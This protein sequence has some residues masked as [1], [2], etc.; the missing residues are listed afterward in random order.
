[1]NSSKSS[2]TSYLGAA[3]N[4]RRRHQNSIINPIMMLR[5][6]L[7][8]AIYGIAFLSL[9]AQANQDNYLNKR[10]MM[11]SLQANREDD[12]RLRQLEEDILQRRRRTNNDYHSVDRGGYIQT[13]TLSS[14]VPHTHTATISTSPT[15]A[16]RYLQTPSE[17]STPL[18]TTPKKDK[19]TFAVV[20]KQLIEFFRPTS[21]GCFDHASRLSKANNI[22][23][24]CLYVGPSEAAD[25]G[26]KQAQMVE[27]ILW[28]EPSE[29][30]PIDG[31]AV[32]VVDEDLMT[33]ILDRARLELGIPV[34]TFDSD[35]PESERS[36]YIGTNNSFFGRQLGRQMES[37]RPQGGTYAIISGE[38]TNLQARANGIIQE[39]IDQTANT[40]TTWEQLEGSPFDAL[41][42]QTLALEKMGEWAQQNP[43]VLLSVTGLPMRMKTLEN[44]DTESPWADFVD[45]HRDRG[46]TLLCADASPHQL[47]FLNYDYVNGLAGQLPYDMGIKSMDTL[48]TLYH[49]P[50]AK[51]ADSEGGDFIG[52]NVVWHVHIPLKLPP[53]TVDMN[54]VGSLKY[55]GYTLFGVIAAFALCLMAWVFWRRNV[56]VIKVAQPNFLLMIA[57]GVIIMASCM[58]PLGMDDF[59]VGGVCM[60]EDPSVH[61][62]AICMGIPWT[63]SIG[64]VLTFS[65]MYA[66]TRRINAIFHSEGGFARVKVSERDVLP[67][68]LLLMTINV[69]ILICWTILDPL[70]YQ[71]QA[72]HSRDEWNRVISTYG[73]CKSENSAA[74]LG[75]IMVVNFAVLVLANWQSYEARNLDAEFSESKYIT[76]CMA[77][78][79]QA[80]I[81]GVP[82]LF[83]VHNLPQAYYLVFVLLCF[84]ICMVILMIMFVPKILY[85]QEFLQLSPAQQQ[86]YMQSAIRRTA[87]NNR[88]RAPSRSSLRNSRGTSS[89]SMALRSMRSL[90]P[91]SR[92]GSSG[93][94]K[95]SITKPGSSSWMQPE[96]QM[97][98]AR[99]RVESRGE[100]VT[101]NRSLGEFRPVGKRLSWSDRSLS[102]EIVTKTDR[103]PSLVSVKELPRE[104]ET[105]GPLSTSTDDD[106]HE[107]GGYQMDPF[108][109]M[110][111]D[112]GGSLCL[113]TNTELSFSEHSRLHDYSQHS[114]QK[115]ATVVG[116]NSSVDIES[117][118]SDSDDDNGEVRIRFTAPHVSEASDDDVEEVRFSRDAGPQS[119]GS[120]D[121]EEEVRIPRNATPLINMQL[122]K[123]GEI[124]E[125]GIQKHSAHDME[126]GDDKQDEEE[127]EI[128]CEKEEEA[129]TPPSQMNEKGD[130]FVPSPSPVT[131]D[132]SGE[133]QAKGS[134]SK[135]TVEEDADASA[136]VICTA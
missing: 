79:L 21:L 131:V 27:D 124:A 57:L 135:E 85:T 66:K 43:T 51:L 61:C 49:N 5:W 122:A 78:M 16:S 54:R 41:N 42:N 37:L 40:D 38:S 126:Q 60:P 30:T 106:P 72:D 47:T 82:L 109:S 23:V 25:R 2:I 65:A 32:S 86:N 89:Q 70:V 88:S 110:A 83:F 59:D 101:E 100:S 44:G 96:C 119:S 123:E 17:Q 31:L 74:F 95:G 15:G 118:S 26:I 73:A 114:Q 56:R 8:L 129:A 94:L 35:A 28:G 34:V 132:S 24:E 121:D 64:F 13:R 68:L 108:P 97:C 71:R 81:S 11:A 4:N 117:S 45:E 91:S 115:L 69:T 22:T 120:D 33:P 6:T 103:R 46:I 12:P 36:Y 53:V 84:I 113:N 48:W 93:W 10:N 67:P 116:G 128:V 104:D 62:T 130:D 136:M 9:G 77:S 76:I 1:M 112:V 29:T 92:Q 107:V 63:A 52:T 3:A 98:A 133:F 58:I 102:S 14:S 111:V 39:L 20:P 134:G 50:E 87:R 99:S 7:G 125:E 105:S 127:M 18:T 75:P 80:M 19:Y 90:T 55:V